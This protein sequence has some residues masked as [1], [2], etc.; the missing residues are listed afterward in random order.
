MGTL[1][2]S[3]DS[4]LKSV[5]TSHLLDACRIEAVQSLVYT[6]EVHLALKQTMVQ[7]GLQQCDA[8]AEQS[9][10]LA[11]YTFVVGPWFPQTSVIS[12][13]LIHKQIHLTHW[14]QL[15]PL[16]RS[17]KPQRCPLSLDSY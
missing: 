15:C 2:C 17:S 6:G 16:W 1:Q 14:L 12:L 13:G 11:M 9:V 5:H 3:L 4:S 7:V 8:Q 10:L